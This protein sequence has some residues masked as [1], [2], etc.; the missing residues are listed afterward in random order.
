MI[1]WK[2][3]EDLQKLPSRRHLYECE[4]ATKT[5]RRG[6][7]RCKLHRDTEFTK[8]LD[9]PDDIWWDMSESD[10]LNDEIIMWKLLRKREI[11]RVMREEMPGR[12]VSERHS[13]LERSQAD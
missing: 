12:K 11:I 1:D 13:K 5:T 4:Y 8:M 6:T 7:V 9:L 2:I 10:D 3:F